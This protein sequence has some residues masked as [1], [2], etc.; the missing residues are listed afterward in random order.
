MIGGAHNHARREASGDEPVVG[1]R[2][3]LALR[4]AAIAGLLA[5]AFHVAHGQFGVGGGAV[6]R[7]TYDWLYDA[8]IISGAVSC[9]ARAA[10]VRR[11]R[12]PWLILG[13]GLAFNASGEVYFSLA[14]GDSGNVPIP[15]LADLF[16]LL[17]YPAAYVALVLLVR[18]RVDRFSATKWLDGAIAATTSAAVIAAVAFEPIASAAGQGCSCAATRWWESGSSP[19][20]PR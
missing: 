13:I 10:L 7:F 18:E 11:E 19:R 6:D 20:R 2:T 1:P 9:L 12:L 5:L 17:Y 16:Y 14:F 3:R 15:S 4:V 8:V